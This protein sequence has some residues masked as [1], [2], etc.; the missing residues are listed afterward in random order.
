M[1][2]FDTYSGKLET[3]GMVFQTPQDTMFQNIS[4][5]SFGAQFR[6]SYENGFRSRI[7]PKKYLG[8][9]LVCM[10]SSYKGWMAG[11]W[12]CPDSGQGRGKGKLL[13][14][15]TQCC[16]QIQQFRYTV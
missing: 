3:S 5:K 14:P 4:V 10:P 11:F 7:W 1:K 12:S 2:T 6:V 8:S 9:L 15:K 13:N 16:F